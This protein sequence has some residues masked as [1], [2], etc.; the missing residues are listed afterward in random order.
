MTIAPSA[1]L[2][3]FNKS[4]RNNID[5][6]NTREVRHWLS[7][8]GQSAYHPINDKT[9]SLDPTLSFADRLVALQFQ[10]F[11]NEMIKLVDALLTPDDNLLRWPELLKMHVLW[12]T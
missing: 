2:R 3:D 5:L 4:L 12:L 8:V 11:A 6:N 10:T 7:D 1:A 9:P